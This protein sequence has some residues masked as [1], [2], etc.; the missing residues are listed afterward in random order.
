[1]NTATIQS[2]AIQ[3]AHLTAALKWMQEHGKQALAPHPE[4]FSVVVSLNSCS[5][6]PGA[7][8]AAVQLGA[9]GR[10]LG[11]EML[12]NAIKDAENTIEILRQQ[13]AREVTLGY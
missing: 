1:M 13:I 12:A 8:E 5:A 6:L 11:H 10:L 2:A 9:Q 4:T 7:K 3:I